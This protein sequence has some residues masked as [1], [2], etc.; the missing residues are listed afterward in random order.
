MKAVEL[1]A[2]SAA[3]LASL[4]RERLLERETLTTGLAA[5]RVKNVR[6]IRSVKRD[7]A[8]ILTICALQKDESR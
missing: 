8:R 7:I 4:L 5:G 6:Q 1:K 3:D 2:K